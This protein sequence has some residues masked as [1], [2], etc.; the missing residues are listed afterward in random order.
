MQPVIHLS[1]RILDDSDLDRLPRQ[2]YEAD[3]SGAAVD[4]QAEFILALDSESLHQKAWCGLEPDCD[5]SL[6]EGRFQAELW[7]RDVAELFILDPAAG[8]YREWNLS[9][10]GAW[11]TDRY[12]AERERDPAYYADLNAASTR[13]EARA[14][15]PGWIARISIPRSEFGELGS[16][17]MNVPMIARQHFLSCCPEAKP[18]PDFHNLHAYPEPILKPIA[19]KF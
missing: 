17:R 9:P 19:G 12:V 11:W 13:G 2:R 3:W 7:K 14:G 4:F 15:E 6:P 18:E 1:D 10:V 5:F 16:C 8:I